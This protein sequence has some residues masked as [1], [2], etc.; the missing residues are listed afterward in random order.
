LNHIANYLK[1][2]TIENFQS[3][4]KTTIEP[5]PPGQLTVITGPS[6]SGK[7]A[8]LRALRWLYVNEPDGDSFIRVGA[9]FARVTAEYESG[10]EGGGHS[11][12]NG[13]VVVRHRTAGG[14]N[15]Y[16]VNGEKLE[17]FGRGGVP[18][19]VKEI[20]GVRPVKIGDLE[21]N[22]NIAEQLSGPFLGSSVSAPARAKVLGKL[23]GTEEIDYA[24]RL[25]G[26]DL[27][28]RGQDEKR[29]E[30]ELKGLEEK[31]KEYDWLPGAKAKIEALEQ[32]AGRIKEAQ[33][34][35]GKLTVLAERVDFF[36]EKIVENQTVLHR[37]RGLVQAE[38][39]LAEATEHRRNRETLITLTDRYWT[40]EKSVLSCKKII[41]KH[42][43]LPE[44]EKTLTVVANNQDRK[45]KLI[46]LANRYR[47]QDQGVKDCQEIIA[48]HA[49]LQGAEEKM[50]AAQAAAER[51]ARLK[52]LRIN[53]RT[54]ATEIYRNQVSLKSLESLDTAEGLLRGADAKKQRLELLKNLSARWTAGNSAV[55]GTQKQIENL[56]SLDKAEEKTTKIVETQARR[57]RLSVLK[58]RHSG[59][60]NKIDDARGQ[61]IVWENR[62]AEL[63]GAYHDLLEDVGVCPLCGQEIKSKVKEAI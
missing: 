25:L 45:E 52:L 61:V 53:Y 8:V 4:V 29:L 36:N 22:L 34:R 20:T 23:A 27:H 12:G 18:L 37:W 41:E 30:S 32:L 54:G 15:R 55:V 40:Y 16:I 57:A 46:S 17:G 28:R 26:T 48:R 10:D 1:K 44:A 56:A 7:T 2:L 47:I 58:D 49:S 13:G 14:T 43:A 59:I 35:M 33:E 19:E 31:V 11:G 42:T 51:V 60:S 39:A 9:T 38:K 3:H 24:N 5:A 63:E 62:V 6:D 21:F 50:L